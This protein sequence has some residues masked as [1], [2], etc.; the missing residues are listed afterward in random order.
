MAVHEDHNGEE[1]QAGGTDLRTAIMARRRRIISQLE[2]ERKSKVITLIHRR[3]PWEE[4]EDDES[5]NEVITIEDSEFVL[6]EIRKTPDETPIDLI[7]HTPGGLALA[8]EM[9]AIAFKHHPAKTTVMV[10]FYA[11]SGGSLIALAADEIHMEPYAVLGP[12]DPQ[13]GGYPAAAYEALL[14]EKPLEAIQDEMVMLAHVARLS[15]GQV[16]SFVKWLIADRLPPEKCE[17]LAEF[18]SGG[19]ITHDTPITLDTVR[20]WGLNVREGVPPEVFEFFTT[21]EFCLCK[22]PCL[23]IYG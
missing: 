6:M 18:L 19:Y 22:R 1:V 3:E 23:A 17:T 8:A 10:P 14:R 20:G 21:C 15:T 2:K 4:E 11:M 5:G 9:I 7:V 13:I 12:V 16:K